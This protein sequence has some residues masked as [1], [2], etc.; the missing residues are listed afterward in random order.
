VTGLID[1]VVVRLDP[2]DGH[3]VQVIHVGRGASGVA[4]GDGA[5]WVA[6]ALDHEVSRIDP[7]SGRVVARIPVDG[8][9]REVAVGA[10]GVWV[11]AD[12]G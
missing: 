8:A 5:V 9:P 2:E 12:A 11:T 3:R 7:A 6:S 1:D 4:A 10:G